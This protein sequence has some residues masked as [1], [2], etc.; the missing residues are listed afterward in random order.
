MYAP[1]RVSAQGKQVVL[2]DKNGETAT[3]PSGKQSTAPGGNSAVP[4][5]NV[6]GDY[7]RTADEA[8]KSDEVPANL[9]DYVRDYFSSLDPKQQK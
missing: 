7:S 5:Q 1:G 4:Y 2:D 9:R 8:L 3:D 6:Y